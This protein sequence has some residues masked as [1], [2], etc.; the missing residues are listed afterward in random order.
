MPTANCWGQKCCASISP[1]SLMTAR[2]IARRRHSPM[3]NG[4]TS[5]AAP[6]RLRM[7]RRP[8]GVWPTKTLPRRAPYPTAR[9]SRGPRGAPSHR[10]VAAEKLGT[11][12]GLDAAPSSSRATS[13][14]SCSMVRGLTDDRH[15]PGPA[16]RSGWQS[17]KSVSSSGCFRALS[18]WHRPGSTRSRSRGYGSRCARTW[19]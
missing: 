4:R 19:L 1:W 7:P 11:I 18:P 12:C 10:P 15:R 13:T 8:T 17:G 3:P 14:V 6:H 5:G 2:C 9:A 16:R